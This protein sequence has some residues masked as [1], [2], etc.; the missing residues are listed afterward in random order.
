MLTS[1]SL[2][3]CGKKPTVASAGHAGQPF[4]RTNRSGRDIKA[5]LARNHHIIPRDPAESFGRKMASKII[6]LI[7]CV[8][9]AGLV[10]ETSAQWYGG[11]GWP[12]YGYEYGAYPYGGY[13]GYGYG[14][15]PYYGGYGGYGGYYGYGKREAGFGPQQPQQ[16]QQ[17]QVQ[18][19]RRYEIQTVIRHL[20]YGDIFKVKSLSSGEVFLM[21]SEVEAVP[22][23]M[24]RLKYL[25]SK[26]LKRNFSKSTALRLALMTLKAIA[27]LHEMGWIHRDIRPA[28][29]WVGYGPDCMNLYLVDFLKIRQYQRS[30]KVHLLFMVIDFFDDQAL[31][32]CKMRGLESVMSKLEFFTTPKARENT[33]RAVHPDFELIADMVN[34]MKWA[35]EMRVPFLEETLRSIAGKLKL[36]LKEPFDWTPEMATQHASATASIDA[37]QAGADMQ[38]RSN[39]GSGGSK[40]KKPRAA[41]ESLR[42]KKKAPS[43]LIGSKEK[44]RTNRL[45]A[46]SPAQ[47]IEVKVSPQKPEQVVGGKDDDEEEEF[48]TPGGGEKDYVRAECVVAGLKKQKPK[49]AADEENEAYDNFKF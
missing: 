29:F 40:S 5:T 14:G 1:F 26:V 39:S 30:N 15:Y 43:R 47:P 35:S 23:D 36:N 4:W 41:E 7:A 6:L 18:N 46:K 34:K 2:S 21:K 12:S 25:R 22:E 45:P 32:W 42:S 9:A 13:G 17:Q 31:P 3:L 48:M 16:Q 38:R 28:Q 37:Y 33:I 49:R 27:D 19:P 20:Q 8:L 11:Y 10:Q 44:S 24:A